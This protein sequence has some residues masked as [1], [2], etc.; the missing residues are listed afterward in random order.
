MPSL[1]FHDAV[2]AG[3]HLGHVHRHLAGAD[4][5]VGEVVVSVL[6]VLGRLQQRLGR[7]AADVGAGAAGSGAASGVFPLVDAG[8]LEAQLG[9]ADG[10]DIAAG[11][12]ADHDDIKCLGHVL[13]L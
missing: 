9:C 2:L 11:A 13:F 6:E 1:L 4:A 5:V 12:A 3:D 8:H 7:D 10:S